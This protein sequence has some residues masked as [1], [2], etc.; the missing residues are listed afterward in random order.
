MRD[1]ILIEQGHLPGYGRQIAHEEQV[2]QM[3]EAAEETSNQTTE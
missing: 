1:D 3:R 2:P